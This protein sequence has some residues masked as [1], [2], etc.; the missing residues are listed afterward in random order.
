MSSDTSVVTVDATGKVTAQ[1]V[2]KANIVV[3]TNDGSKAAACAYT[4]IATAVNVT[5][6]TL[7]QTTSALS[8]GQAETLQATVAP[9]DATYPAVKWASSNSAVATV[10]A[11]GKVTAVA[12]GTATVTA[13]TTDG[14]KQATCVYTVT[15]AVSPKVVTG[16][17]IAPASVA[18]MTGKTTTLKATVA[19]STA[20]QAVVWASAKTA[21]ATV[22]TAGVVTGKVSGTGKSAKV[23]ITVLT[24][25]GAKTAT[26]TVQVYTAQDVQARLNTLACRDAAAKK[27]VVDGIFGTNSVNALKNWQKAAG[28]TQNGTPSSA[29]LTG[30]FATTA[31][32]CGTTST[33]V[34]T[35][36][37][38]SPTS[39]SVMT[40]KTTTLKAIVSP[41]NANATVVWTSAKTATATVSTTGVVTGK[42]TGVGKSA[43]VVITVMTKSGAKTATATVQVYTAQD[44]QTQ[45]NTLGCKDAA[46]KKLVV[47]GIFGT[48]STNALKNW[49]KAAGLTQNGTPSSA[50]LNGLFAATAPKC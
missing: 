1:G 47:D 44:V 5:G 49:Q 6:V 30:L 10:D 3:M 15:A 26:A 17:T 16:V 39:V 38:V 36:V 13:T 18:V 23:V 42:V 12:V 29:T 45:L 50:T 40:G 25:S 35:S 27:L 28:L 14:N 37:A 21:T 24:T 48:N 34:P 43:K 2:G 7:N 31:P 33:V 9:L 8:V 20:S 19:P 4:V 41:T 11:S 22:S 46:A 32:K